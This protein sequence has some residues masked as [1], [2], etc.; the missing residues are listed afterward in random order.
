[1]PFFINTQPIHTSSL[2]LVSGGCLLG[3]LFGSVC[4][5]I[6]GSIQLD[7]LFLQMQLF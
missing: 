6:K 5:E 3:A 4:P 7:F 1:M 2:T